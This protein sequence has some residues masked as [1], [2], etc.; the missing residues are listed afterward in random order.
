MAV[1][2]S[3]ILNASPICPMS[4]SFSSLSTAAAFIAFSISLGLSSPTR[5]QSAA[6]LTARSAALAGPQLHNAIRLDVGGVVIGSLANALVG[7]SGMLTPLLFSYERQISQ[8]SSL[9]AEGLL[10][11]GVAWERK[12]GVSLQNRYYVFPVHPKTALQGLYVAPVVGYRAMTLDANVQLAT[13]RS[14][15]GAGLMVGWQANFPNC[16]QFFFDAALGAMSWHKVGADR[17]QG[18]FHPDYEVR[19]CFYER[20][21]V[22]V[23]GRLGV[24]IR[25]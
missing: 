23:D 3:G 1:A 21:A 10:N 15:L 13:R 9:V 8:H 14:L 4:F 22:L 19:P 24:G 25:F 12:A 16:R 7:N 17:V 5:A 11:G 6:E 18:D 20:S 2:I